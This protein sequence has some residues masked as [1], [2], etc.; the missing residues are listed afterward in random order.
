VSV[1][2]GALLVAGV[3]MLV[4][5]GP[6]LLVIVAGLALLATEFAWAQ[7]PLNA[8]KARVRRLRARVDR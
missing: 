4:L 7:R 6:G 5:P 2:G 3:A 1:G 8:M